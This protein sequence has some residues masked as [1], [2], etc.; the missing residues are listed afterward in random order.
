MK[1]SKAIREKADALKFENERLKKQMAEYDDMRELLSQLGL[2]ANSS[3]WAFED[4]ITEREALFP[5]HHVW[6][7]RDLHRA[8]GNA[9]RQLEPKEE[10]EAAA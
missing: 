8:L 3:K 4:R 10:N 5:K 6:A 7:M 2:E 1:V 9:L